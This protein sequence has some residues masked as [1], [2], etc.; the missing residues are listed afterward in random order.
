[1]LVA[2]LYRRGAGWR[3]RAVGQG[4]DHGLADLARHYGVDNTY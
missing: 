2:E 4:Y 3:M 1:M